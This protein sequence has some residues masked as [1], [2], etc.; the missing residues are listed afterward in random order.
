[1]R[2]VGMSWAHVFHYVLNL[3]DVGYVYSDMSVLI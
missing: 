1:V 3:R 2:C